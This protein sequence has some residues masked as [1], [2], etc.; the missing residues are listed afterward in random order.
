VAVDLH[1]AEMRGTLEVADQ[2]EAIRRIK[3]MGLFPT[4][5]SEKARRIRPLMRAGVPGKSLGG[6]ISWFGGRVKSRNLAVFTRQLATLIDAG[7]PLLRGLRLLAEQEESRGLKKTIGGV[8][9]SIEN[10][11]SLADAMGQYPRA[12]DGLYIN[13]VKAGELSGAL[14]TTLMRLA[15]FR[16]K[17]QRIKGRV[18]G[19]MVYPCAVLFVAVAIL[20]LLMVYVV[21]RFKSIFDGLS[22]GA[23]LPAFTL[24][25]FRISEQIQRH[26]I[27]GLISVAAIAG[28]LLLCRQTAWGREGID[29]FKLGSPILGPV[30]RKAAISRFSRTLGTLVGNGVPIL[31]ALTI[32]KETAGNVL[33]GR[34]VARLHDNVKEGDAIAPTLKAAGIFPAMVSGMVDVGEQ[35]GAL[36]ELLIKVADNY[37]EEVDTAVGA[38]TSLMEPIMIVLL[39]VIVGAIVIAVF[40]PLVNLNPVDG[41]NRDG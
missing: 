21:P 4:R 8:A 14:E 19:A 11:S 34:V 29:R 28:L 35:T 26:F 10:G 27:L 41:A 13:M 39:A 5:V 24:F 25:V 22:N 40:L 20:M 32:V 12:F 17:A 9:L 6:P 33:V 23:S 30:F 31:Q 18:K 15:E 3:E 7:M 38:M 37:D 16:E 36:P 1:G 2:G